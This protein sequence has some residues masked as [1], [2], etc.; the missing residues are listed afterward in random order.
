MVTTCKHCGQPITH[1]AGRLWHN[2]SKVLPQYCWVNPVGGSRMHQPIEQGV[3][4][5][6]Q[7][8]GQT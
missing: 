8:Q 1:I 2:E 7:H 6:N 5:E 3:E 4:N